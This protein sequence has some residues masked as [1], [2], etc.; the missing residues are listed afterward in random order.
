[1]WPS[2]PC[3]RC[4]RWSSIWCARRNA[5]PCRSS[6][7]AGSRGTS[8]SSPPYWDTGPGQSI[9]YLAHECVAEL[10]DKGMLDKDYHT[11]I[12]AYN[13]AVLHG[14]VKT[15]AKM[16]ISTLQSYQSARI[17]EAVGIRQDVIDK[18]F[19]NTVSRV[20]GIGLEEIAQSVTY[21]HDHAFDP[22][23]LGVDTTLDSTGFHRL[24]SGADKEDHLYNPETIVALQQATQ[25]GDYARFK[26]Y[27]AMVDDERRPHTLRG[28]LEFA[29]PE[30][31][32]IPIE[33]V[34]P[35]EVIV[36]RFKTGAMSYGSISAEAHECMAE[37]MNRLGAKSN[38]GEGGEKPERLGTEKNSANTRSS[39]AASASP[40]STW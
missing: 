22:L 5:Q 38:S 20:G 21:R 13:S 16:G 35:A 17:F 7:R 27:T 1:M 6:W 18:Y 23:G 32:G 11:A 19:A 15:A 31:G 40:A 34:E 28:T 12:E 8:I 14:I 3:W 37:A 36:R 33:E 39:V 2:L 30:D 10:I 25:R 4:R 29:F 9:P 26:E 24:R